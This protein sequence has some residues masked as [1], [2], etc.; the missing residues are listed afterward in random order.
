MLNL[1]RIQRLSS[2]A[3]LP[4]KGTRDSTGYD[5]AS[6]EDTIINPGERILVGTGLVMDLSRDRKS[7]V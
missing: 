5:L 2:D 6:N 4:S 1:I 3:V 7:V